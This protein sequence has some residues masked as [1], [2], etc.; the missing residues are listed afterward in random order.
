[1][2]FKTKNY[3]LALF[4]KDW[5]LFRKEKERMNC[6]DLLTERVML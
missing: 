5:S 1:M 6:V 2:K 3:G 4:Q